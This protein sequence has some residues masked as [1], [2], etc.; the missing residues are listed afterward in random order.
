MNSQQRAIGL[1]YGVIGTIAPCRARSNSPVAYRLMK[2]KTGELVL[3]GAFQWTEGL[4]KSGI[5]WEDLP[6]EVEA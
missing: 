6:T 1:A 4:N 2:K 5:D 3:Q